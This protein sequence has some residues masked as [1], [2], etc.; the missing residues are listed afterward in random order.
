MNRLRRLPAFALLAS[1]A[2]FSA[3]T[4]LRTDWR[5]AIAT[6][7][8][9]LIPASD[10]S[11][12]LAAV[13]QLAGDAQARAMLA[14][15][16]SPSGRAAEAAEAARKALVSDPATPGIACVNPHDMTSRRETGV[17]LFESRFALLFPRGL[18]AARAGLAA[19]GR[20]ATPD[21]LAE[22]A[23][24][25]LDAFMKTDAAFAFEKLL[26]A[27]PLLLIPDATAPLLKEAGGKP[28]PGRAMLWIDTGRPPLAREGQTPVFEAIS[29][30]EAA[31]RA[32]VPDAI[33]RYTGV[34][35]FAAASEQGIRGEL[36][37]L[38]GVALAGV[39]LVCAALLRRVA[40]LPHVAIVTALSAA[41]AW[42][43]TLV[44][45]GRIHVFAIALGALLSGICVD[46][47]L[48]VLLHEGADGRPASFARLRPLLRPLLAAGLTAVAGFAFLALSPLPAI[49]QTGVFITSGVFAAL[50]LSVAYGSLV[51]FR[52]AGD[53]APPTG[54]KRSAA[55]AGVRR[56]LPW[57]L[58]ALVAGTP[59]VRW[60]DT[61]HDLEYPLPTLRATDREIRGAFGESSRAPWLVSG[62]TCGESLSRLRAFTE[63]TEKI[64]GGKLTVRGPLGILAT[65]EEHREA[66]AFVRAEGV[67]YAEALK[68]ALVRHGY[69]AAD[70]APFFAAWEKLKDG[71]PDHESSA[72]NFLAALTGPESMLVSLKGDNRLLVCWTDAGAPPPEPP[73]ELGAFPLN[74]LESLNRTLGAY[75]ENMLALTLA[76]FAFTVL[77]NLAALRRA[78]VLRDFAAP[79]AVALAAAGAAGWCGAP[80][81]MFHL[82]GA[83]LA[84]CSSL[85]YSVFAR[86][87]RRAG[88]PFPKAVTLAWATSATSFG[89]LCFSAIPA[90]FALGATVVSIITG[91]YLLVRFAP[92]PPPASP[93]LPRP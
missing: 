25:R 47:T 76:G 92:P 87:A 38:N 23:A 67:A 15:V 32:R 68:K 4:L 83:F 54:G 88:A 22:H 40:I 20:P 18:A 63:R 7:P 53:R 21:E 90:L 65:P 42:S 28:A 77:A 56:A 1:A 45:F 58:A 8:L 6:S 93:L 9:E 75:R 59:F 19:Q 17:K 82:A 13:R 2:L 86:E 48:Y 71:L 51:R 33:L 85:N 70:F 69:E 39:A 66:S 55:R 5:S 16:D 49:R 34:N 24:S 73:A 52:H 10:T 72:Q 50:V 26:P 64:S 12:E 74:R 27:D 37:L 79:A 11:R 29:R 14:L 43:A 57:A 46:Y 61:L 3:I 41:V 84:L 80:L 31:M 62:K 44:A 60:N 30:A 81:T 91:T 36:S 78:D 35:A 89:A